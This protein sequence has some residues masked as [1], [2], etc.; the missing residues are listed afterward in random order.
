MKTINI[1]F[2]LVLSALV[3]NGADTP[4]IPS[5]DAIKKA[6]AYIY[7]CDCGNS[8]ADPGYPESARVLRDSGPAIVPALVELV[9]DKTLSAW[10]AGNAGRV[11]TRHPLSEPLRAALR[12]RRE[13]KSFDSDP[14]A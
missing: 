7:S 9:P 13:D 11:A 8:V 14:G 3:A 1:L 10:F 2:F 5:K 6:A 4:A 12:L